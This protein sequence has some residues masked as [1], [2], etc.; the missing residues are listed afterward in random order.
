MSE[1]GVTSEK[2]VYRVSSAMKKVTMYLTKGSYSA[3]ACNA[4]K[5]PKLKTAL[6]AA[7]AALVRKECQDLCTTTDGLTSVL[8]NTSPGNLKKFSWKEVLDEL[9][10]KAPVLYAVLNAS[11][12][13]F[14][15]QH[16]KKV[17][18]R[19][20]A[21]AACILLRQRNKFMCA[22]QCVI[23]VLLHAGHA[24]KMVSLNSHSLY[25]A[26]RFLLLYISVQ[27]I[28]S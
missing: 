18:Q 28:A 5:I 8:R 3:F 25:D 7:V 11:V 4:V 20:V 6:V 16:P 24:S 27:W 21:F 12:S 26:K 1:S 17:S 15:K 19:S 2:K 13:R 10:R 9:E 14:R 23:S 22:A